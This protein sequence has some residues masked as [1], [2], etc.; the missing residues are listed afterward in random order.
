M[1]LGAS[2]YF[3]IPVVPD[4]FGRV[5]VSMFT[6]DFFAQAVLEIASAGRQDRPLCGGLIFNIR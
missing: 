5:T 4:D 2:S 6:K 3:I 1:M